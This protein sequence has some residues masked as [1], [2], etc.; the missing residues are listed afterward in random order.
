ME[1]DQKSPVT[2]QTVG[3]TQCLIC[4]GRVDNPKRHVCAERFLFKCHRCGEKF[5]TTLGHTRVI[6]TPCREKRRL[7]GLTRKVSSLGLH[8]G[9]PGF[10][11]YGFIS[12]R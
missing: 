12:A 6:C 9:D 1:Q 5:M 10:V 8:P 3:I 11:G 4:G 2:G 7:V